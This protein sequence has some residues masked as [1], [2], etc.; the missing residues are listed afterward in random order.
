MQALVSGLFE[1][2]SRLGD[3]AQLAF[4]GLDK[5]EQLILDEWDAAA[6]RERSSRTV[7]AQEAIHA[8]E[9][10]RELRAVNQALGSVEDLRR[11]LADTVTAVGGVV[12]GNDPLRLRLT[13]TPE[14]VRDAA[15]GAAEL[16]FTAGTNAGIDAPTPSGRT[17]P[18]AHL[19]Q[20]GDPFIRDLAA[21]VL[22]A[23]LDRLSHGP[24]R[25]AGVIRSDAVTVLTT[26]LL[27]RHRFDLTNQREGRTV[28]LL[29][30]DAGIAAFTG[31]PTAP[32]WLAPADAEQLLDAAPTGNVSPEQAREF[33]GDV[34]DAAPTWLPALDEDARRRAADLLDAHRRV[35]E[36]VQRRAAS[37]SV[38][39]R[40]PPDVLGIYVLL[41]GPGR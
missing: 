24:A 27:V 38:E 17:V 6:E 28:R 18:A 13:E 19:F 11:F 5:E 39:P 22:D 41:P 34:L 3:E 37:Y 26:V 32:T 15:R 2:G 16:T 35:R 23:A 1:R 25:R 20:R 10:D 4:E 8:D 40:L 7:F 31:L 12:I 36:A 30:E 14:P 9:V 29:A 33:L 21:Y